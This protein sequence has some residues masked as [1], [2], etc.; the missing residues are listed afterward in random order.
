[1]PFW[2][3]DDALPESGTRTISAG[4]RSA[5][6]EAGK[7]VEGPHTLC[8]EPEKC[9]LLTAHRRT[10]MRMIIVPEQW[11]ACYRLC[12][13]LWYSFCGSK[14]SFYINGLLVLSCN[15]HPTLSHGLQARKASAVVPPRHADGV[16][17]EQ[18]HAV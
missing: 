14:K 9:C 11:V 6:I 16:A 10:S 5:A 13:L 12:V 17:H 2:H 18:A 15:T 7:L 8:E 1:M 3:H 4:S